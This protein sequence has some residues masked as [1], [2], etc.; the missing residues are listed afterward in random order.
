MERYFLEPYR[1]I[2]PFR[3]TFWCR[4]AAR[5]IPRHLRRS[6]GVKLWQFRGT[7]LLEASIR[8]GAGVLLA[9]N[10]C[11]WSDPM[12]LGVMGIHMRRYLYYVASYHL[13][14]QSR[15]MGWVLNRIGGYSIWREGADRESIKATTRI[16]AEAER[17]VVLFPEGTW[18]RQNDRV[19]PLQEGLSLITRQAA[20]QAS[21][22]IVIH[23]TG[24]KYWCLSDPT[25]EA[26]R[27]LD[28]LERRIGWHAQDH[29]SPVARVEKLGAALVAL[30]E[31]EYLGSTRVGGLDDRIRYLVE[32]QVGRLEKHH[33]GKAH[34]GHA[35]ERVRR[36]RQ[37]LMRKLM[38]MSAKPEL[39]TSLKADL[40]VLL[41]CE[42]LNAHSLEYLHDHPT[43]ERLC[44]TIL[45]I[46]E[47]LTDGVEV[48]LV[49]MGVTV[50]VGP[51]IDVR[52]LNE[53]RRGGRGPD[54]MVTQLREG[55]Q[56][57]V[58]ALLAEG[59]PPA[60]GCPRQPPRT[61]EHKPLSP[62]TTTAP[63]PTGIGTG[64]SPDGQPVN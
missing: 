47:T 20:R 21:R 41:L 14:R 62:Q 15:V 26:G 10:H 17:P 57:Q 60:W 55:I 28:R 16:L 3:S 30:K 9:P 59:P 46:E 6:M 54:P 31:M 25:P 38:E 4:I 45:R 18:F 33:L 44:E 11:R 22:P 36:L 56:K 13:F 64:V 48:P 34:D 39:S 1:F 24:I 43:P 42:N 52:T 8:N 23:P 19:G 27:R 50:S 61:A 35:L 53:D 37:Q 29:L 5:L 12:V 58:D 32:S 63:C 40:D 2:P 51:A 49:P 7:E